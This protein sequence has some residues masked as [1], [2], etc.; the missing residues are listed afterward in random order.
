MEIPSKLSGQAILML[1]LLVCILCL[2]NACSDPEFPPATELSISTTVPKIHPDYTDLTIPVNIASLHFQIEE[3]GE[4]FKVFLEGSK[5][6]RIQMKDRSGRFYVSPAKWKAFL[7]N[8]Q[9]SAYTIRIF[10]KEKGQWHEFAPIVNRISRDPIDPFLAYRLIPPG[11][12]TWS[13]M[14]L[15]QRDLTTFRERP[16]LENKH[17]EENCINCHSFAGGSS[18]NMMFHIRGSLGGTIIKTDTKIEKV[19]LKREETLS[20]GVYPSFHPSGAYIAYSTNKIEQYFHAHP[21]RSI[22][23]FD[24]QSDLVLYHINSG[25]VTHVPGT[26]GDVYMETFPNWSPD[27]RY[28]YFSRSSAQADTPFDSIRYNI[29]RM[30]FD[31]DQAE[32]GPAEPVFVLTENEQSASFP[33]ISPD[34]KYLLITVHNYGTFPIWHK[35]ADLCLVNLNTGDIRY[36]DEINSDESDSFHCW[37]SNSRW[38]VFSSRRYDGL[39]TR[40]FL[41]HLDEDGNF[42]KPFLLP[43]KDPQFYENLFFSYNVPELVK[44]KIELTP[45]DWA[46]IAKH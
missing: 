8:N 37:S 2:T 41:A 42:H 20:A 43:Q 34:G 30:A 10:K 24:R 22:E 38:I 29:Y 40:I 5:G 12:E 46:N 21:E 4:T 44:N 13:T 1:S 35:E 45:R 25:E 23:V 36:P 7:R 26:R 18:K 3:E 6:D 32:F 14:G 9:G 11:Y 17:L 15:Y 27:G 31:P 16:I 33:R 19:N 28:L 39:H